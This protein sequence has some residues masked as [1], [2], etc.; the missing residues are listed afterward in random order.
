MLFPVVKDLVLV[1]RR[2]DAI[3][4]STERQSEVWTICKGNLTASARIALSLPPSEKRPRNGNEV[5]VLM[6]LDGFHALRLPRSR[7]TAAINLR[8]DRAR[9]PTGTHSRRAKH[10]LLRA[11]QV[12][13]VAQ[14]RARA[15]L[16]ARAAQKSRS[17][18][19]AR[20]V[21][22]EHE[23]IAKFTF[24]THSKCVPSVDYRYANQGIISLWISDRNTFPAPIGYTTQ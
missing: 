22:M 12:G 11:G 3:W 8:P 6:S 17:A 9:R 13:A 15:F 20:A 10:L 18:L 14:L 5:S 19:P 1:S 7:R 21:H 16:T 2:G 4:R 23:R 24:Q